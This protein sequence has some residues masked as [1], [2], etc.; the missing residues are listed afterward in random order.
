MELK[1]KTVVELHVKKQISPGE[2]LWRPIGFLALLLLAPESFSQPTWLAADD[3]FIQRGLVPVTL[4][5]AT[6]DDDT[7]DTKAILAALAAARDQG[8]ATYIP[9]GTYLV[10]DTLKCRQRVSHNGRRWV[11]QRRKPCVVIGAGGGKRPLLKLVPNA[12]GFDDPKHPKALMWFWSQPVRGPHAGSEDPLH[13]DPTIS[14][15]QVIKGIN[16][17][18]R[19]AKNSGAVAIRHAGAQGSTIEDVSILAQGAF[20]GLYDSP[21]Q[22]GGVYNV[23][24]L[25][26][27]YG[28][29]GT[30]D[31]RYP[32][33]VGCKFSNQETA[34]I[35][36]SGNVVL[37]LV[38]FSIVKGSPGPVI[39]LQSGGPIYGRGF[40]LVDGVIESSGPTAIDNTA[41]KTLTITNVY[42]K[43]G[44]AVVKSARKPPVLNQGGW[45]WLEEYAYTGKGY[46]SMID[47]EIHPAGYELVKA[48]ASGPPPAEASFRRHLWGAD[49][50][51]FDDPDIVDV[52]RFGARP[53][54][55][56][57][58]TNAI[59]KAL[60]SNSKVFLPKGVFLVKRP[61]VLGPSNQLFGI[62][63]T[64]SVLRENRE[65]DPDGGNSLVTT[66][67]DRKASSSLSFL[68][69]ETQSVARTPLHWRAGEAS[70]VRDIMAGP[71][72][73]Y[74]GQRTGAPRHAYH[75]SDTG[76][77]RWYAIAAEWG[78]F[79]GSTYDPAYS[80]L[81]VDGTNGP[82]A[83]YGLNVERDALWPQAVIRN[84][85][86]I[87]IYYFK[88]E[89]AEWP[90]G[91]TPPGV[92]LVERSHGIRLFGMTGNAHPPG[93]A[94]IT[95]DASDNILLAHV[96]GFKP[97]KAFSNIVETRAAISRKVS[98]DTP[99]ALFERRAGA[100]AVTEQDK[101]HAAPAVKTQPH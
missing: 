46:V 29:Y 70:I 101:R 83:F 3:V 12:A 57:D 64:F 40:A 86:N 31:S 99:L 32:V 28:V 50:P 60:D 100:K 81:L 80:H 6:P 85:S 59:Q 55:G 47:G 5:G 98:G 10:S 94:L 4:F 65:W 16:I 37:V 45:T 62:G 75:I 8:M 18:L 11:E 76:G 35:H 97:G 56:V 7:D 51:S 95:L 48:S 39:S 93:S 92:L 43:T 96:A 27:R 61:L 20:A 74:Y 91:T 26:G 52:R 17:D 72:S 79:Y 34:A 78:R 88:A 84:S 25:G 69:L 9:S 77:G 21:G 19:A 87:D 36:W 24:V 42:F 44:G 73:S 33:L 15:N 22:G 66:V 41:G 71:V 67:A 58:D 13:G 1:V 38:D 54:D 49:F 82:L 2:K 14:F 30:A 89:A 68:L 23:H 53:D 63:K 90:K